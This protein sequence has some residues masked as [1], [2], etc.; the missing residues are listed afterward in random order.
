MN[1]PYLCPNCKTNRSSFNL[2]EQ[3]A[4]PVKLNPQTGEILQQFEIEHLEPF[5]LPYQ[6]PSYKVQ[7]GICGVIENEI[8]FIKQAQTSNFTR[9]TNNPLNS[10]DNF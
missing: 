5:H 6:G 2:I 3:V 9:K 8:V 4:R 7:C 10:A 1:S